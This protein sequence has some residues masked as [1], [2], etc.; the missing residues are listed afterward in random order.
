MRF[1]R[2]YRCCSSLRQGRSA[3]SSLGLVSGALVCSMLLTPLHST[4][5]DLRQHLLGIIPGI[6][7]GDS[8]HQTDACG[9]YLL[10][11]STF[12][13]SHL[14]VTSFRSSVFRCL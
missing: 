11:L 5:S 8:S 6:G 7:F 12:H 9:W 2:R 10:M 3:H 14:L 13:E 4:L 1:C